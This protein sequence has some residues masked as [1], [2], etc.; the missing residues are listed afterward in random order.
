MT[1]VATAASCTPTPHRSATVICAASVRPRSALEQSAERD[2]VVERDDAVVERVMQLAVGRRDRRVVG[3][4]DVGLREDARLELLLLRE[5]RAH[6]RDV[7]AG[8]HPLGAHDRLACRR[9]RH[10]EPRAAN[11][12]LHVRRNR[13]VDAVPRAHLGRVRVGAA[14]RRDDDARRRAHAEERLELVPRLAAGADDRSLLH[15]VRCEEVGGERA[16][17]AGAELGEV[18]VVE[19]DRGEDPRLGGEDEEEA[20][21]ERQAALRVA[22]EAGGGLHRPVRRAVDVRSLQVRLALERR[23]GEIHVRGLRHLAPVQRGER[24]AHRPER[25][26]R[27]DEPAHVF[28]GERE[29]LRQG[30]P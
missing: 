27:A 28:L 20:V 29:H 19:E 10:D 30:R 12:G 14:A 22:P 15:L 9:R 7:R 8:L 24:E 25:L 13:D 5:V 26:R 6:R 11:G 18:A 1:S 23:E 17:G 2:D 3:G 16:R 4:H 21:R